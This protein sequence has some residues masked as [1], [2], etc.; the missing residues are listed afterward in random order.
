MTP[1]VFQAEEFWWYENSAGALH[2][3]LTIAYMQKVYEQYE[4]DPRYWR[5]LPRTFTGI[6]E[7]ERFA[8]AINCTK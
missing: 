8:H 1:H 5:S 2:A 3:F 7:S 4:P 6:S